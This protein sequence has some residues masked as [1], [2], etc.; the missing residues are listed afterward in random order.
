VQT[1]GVRESAVWKRFTT[2]IERLQGS[3][4]DRQAQ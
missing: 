3:E 1:L 4:G 2:R